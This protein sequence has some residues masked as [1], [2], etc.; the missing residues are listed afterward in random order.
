LAISDEVD[1]FGK[2]NKPASD[3]ETRSFIKKKKGCTGLEGNTSAKC[4]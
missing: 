4:F 3:E 2:K 1:W